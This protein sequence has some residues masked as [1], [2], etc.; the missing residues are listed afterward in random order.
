MADV[1]I[2]IDTGGT[3]TDVV[4]VD[5]ASGRRVFHKLP[6]NT[7]DPARA[8]LDGT[9]A[10]LA[11]AKVAASRVDHL[12]LGTTLATNAVIER[13]AAPTALLTTR[14][15]RDVLEL[16]R[17]RRPHVFNLEI[18]KP[19]PPAA[20]DRRIELGER[21]GPDGAV[22]RALD[23]AELDAAI[24]TLKASGVTAV[25]ICL[26]HAYANPSHEQR[27]KAALAERW[28]AAHVSASSDAM[29]EFRE[30]ERFATTAV[31]ASLM[32]V[33]QQYLAR[34]AGGIADLGVPVAPH[35]MQSNGGA[36]SPE[37]V[38]ALPINTFFSGPAGGVI[39][40]AGLA[41]DA[42]LP[43]IISFD[44]GGTSTDVCLVKDGQPSRINQREIAGF[45]V[46]T[47]TIDLH[48]IGAGGGS[49]AWVDAGGLPKVGPM[50]AGAQPGPAAYGQGGTRPTVTDANVVLGRLNPRA[51]L[52]GAMTV[53]P[54]RAEA[55][56]RDGLAAPLAMDLVDAAAGVIEIVNVNMMGAVRVI[57]VERGEDP[58]DFA[59]FAFGGAGPL[60]AAE[61]ADG[62]AI[63]RIVVPPHPGLM[64]AIG[65][66]HAER[67]GDFGLTRLVPVQPES[68]PA[69]RD[70]LA[71]LTR[72]GEDWLARE[73]IARPDA[74]REWLVE[75]RYVG[76]S[77]E[78]PLALAGDAIDAADLARL[79]VAFHA[80]H[81]MRYG[82]DMPEHPIELVTVRLAV[83]A[84]R[85]APPGETRAAGAATL[86]GARR[87]TRS[88]WFPATGFV[89]TPVYDRARLPADAV[90]AGPAIVEQMDATTVVP[91]DWDLRVDDA[92]NLILTREHATVAK[93]EAWHM[94]L[95]R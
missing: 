17:Q 49:V 6:S 14:G 19:E 45:P 76:Q 37:A 16:A 62:M 74:R 7:A 69:I 78:L 30:F 87:E 77:S 66:L 33:M 13:R 38:Q 46:R 27:V 29:A 88:V 23:D 72:R 64:S 26:L 47:A 4:L 61:V 35:V 73:N 28:P 39:G 1:W 24:D 48:T 25:A 53:Y 63:R 80:A 15:F 82:Y 32:P 21:I 92:G 22:I 20:R 12:V 18:P 59:L 40:A 71:A 90:L 3:F 44:M 2:G 41:R 70:A 58:R 95:T 85:P 10:I 65:L 79:M 68:L 36:A 8:I 43:D 57:S 9:A 84:A 93:A 94:Q 34:F 42:G 11:L 83:R 52:D 31:N 67:R 51:L 55:A 81:R 86:A 60:H 89:G 5:F 50:S 75:F 91:P 56:L 54:E